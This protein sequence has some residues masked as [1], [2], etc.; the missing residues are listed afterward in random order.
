MASGLS[1][2]RKHQHCQQGSSRR[3]ILLFTSTNDGKVITVFY[4]WIYVEIQRIQYNGWN[5]TKWFYSDENW[6]TGVFWVVDYESA[7]RFHEFE[8]ADMKNSIWR[9]RNVKLEQYLWK[10][11]CACFPGRWSMICHYISEMQYGGSNEAAAV[12][13]NHISYEFI[14]LLCHYLILFLIMKPR[15]SASTA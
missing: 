13:L 10:F 9:P 11:V 5:F 6:Y 3:I 8:M 15:C 2:R 1:L 12:L 7:I 4:V 14:F